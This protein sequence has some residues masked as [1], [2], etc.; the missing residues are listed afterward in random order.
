MMCGAM[1]N[2][3]ILTSVVWISCAVAAIRL[4]NADPLAAALVFTFMIGVFW[5]LVHSGWDKTW[6]Q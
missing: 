6:K 3:L 5:I 4:D 1:N 2:Y